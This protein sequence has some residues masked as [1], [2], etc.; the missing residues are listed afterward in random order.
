MWQMFVICSYPEKGRVPDVVTHPTFC[1]N[2]FGGFA[3]RG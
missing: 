2:P 3:P 1:G